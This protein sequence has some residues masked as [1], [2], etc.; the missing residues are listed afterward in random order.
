M[1]LTTAQ[2][3]SR[4]CTIAKA[5]GYLV[6]AGQYLNMLLDTLCQTYNFDYIAKTQ[7]IS[8]TNSPSYALS[9]DHLRTKEVY[10][11]VNGSIFY[12]FQIPLETYHSLFNGPGASNYPNKYA[13]DVSTTPYTILFYPPPSISQ[14]VTVKYYPRMPDITTPE[15]D[16]GTPWFINQ[17]YLIRK[18]ASDVML[19]T[20]DERQP[21]FE[22]QSEKMLSK[23]LAMDDDKQGFSETVKLSR[24]RFRTGQNQ[25][26][27]KAFPLG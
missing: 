11:S 18:V 12:L 24:E 14:D 23:I 3:I 4:A 19:E 22:V 8:L 5:P 6:Q 25:T 15:S 27:N 17:E 2:I 7:T 20:D 1:P 13:I 26:P 16:T 10:Y 21:L 9:S